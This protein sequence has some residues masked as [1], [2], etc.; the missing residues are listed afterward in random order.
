MGGNVALMPNYTNVSKKNLISVWR[1]GIDTI[2]FYTWPRLPHGKVTKT[3]LNI[4]NESQEVSPFPAGDHK[5]AMNRRESISYLG[6]SSNPPLN[7]FF[8]FISDQH[9]FKSYEIHD[10]PVRLQSDKIC[11]CNHI[12]F[13]Y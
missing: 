4:T 11:L 12:L 13:N 6:T 10:L 1:S 3:Q 2:K 5:A 7:M 9:Y 8:F